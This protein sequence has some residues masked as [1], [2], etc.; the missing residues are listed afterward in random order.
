MPSERQIAG[1]R[2]NARR[3]TGPKSQTGKRRSSANALCHGLSCGIVGDRAAAGVDA[4]AR[5]LVGDHA[6]EQILELAHRVVRAHLDLLRVREIKRNLTER[7]YR[8]GALDP[9]PRFRSRSAE[10]TCIRYIL[11]HPL[12]RS[13]RWPDPV[14]PLGPMPTEHAARAAEATRRLL[15]ELGKLDRYERR[16]FSAKQNALRKL[17]DSLKFA[18]PAV[19]SGDVE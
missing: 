8:V 11:S 4:L 7:V 5:R 13:L 3:S 10:L 18:S 19:R 15:P 16:A 12:D 9:L 14:D 6:D 1:N 17:A 2:R